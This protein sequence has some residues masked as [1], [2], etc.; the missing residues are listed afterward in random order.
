MTEKGQ[1]ML[2]G[3]SPESTEQ[4][5]GHS[6]FD[7]FEDAHRE[8]AKR[9]SAEGGGTTIVRI[10]HSPYGGFMVRLVHADL[11]FEEGIRGIWSPGGRSPYRNL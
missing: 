2:N 1:M 6:Y 9:R 10:E 8:A 5:A 4:E 7:N 3:Q 11:L